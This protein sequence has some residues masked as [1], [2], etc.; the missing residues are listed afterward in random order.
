MMVHNYTLSPQS[1]HAITLYESVVR[2]RILSSQ[3]DDMAAQ[4]LGDRD[5]QQQGYLARNEVHSREGMS[6]YEEVRISFSGSKAPLWL[7][8]VDRV[9]NKF[10]CRLWRRK[11]L[12]CRRRSHRRWSIHSARGNRSSCPK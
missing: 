12:S 11:N 2:E 3:Y 1:K 6:T 9:N 10:H 4:L 5:Q 7:T 8:M